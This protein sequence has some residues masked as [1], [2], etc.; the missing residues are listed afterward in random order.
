MNV[1]GTVRFNKK[2]IPEELKKKA[3]ERK[4]FAMSQD[5]DYK[6]ARQKTSYHSENSAC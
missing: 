3:R 4:C 6:V 2:N 1:V 5:D